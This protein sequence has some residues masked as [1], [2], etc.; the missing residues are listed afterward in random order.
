MQTNN[1]SGSGF[2]YSYDEKSKTIKIITNEHVVENS[3]WVQV[4]NDLG[5]S[6]DATIDGEDATRD[7]A[8]LSAC[9]VTFS[10]QIEVLSLLDSSQIKAGTSIFVIG[11]PR[12]VD[13]TV[14]TSGIVSAR[15]FQD[16]NDRWIIQTDAAMNPGNSG[17]PLL[18]MDGTVVGINTYGI[19]ESGG[20]RIEGQGF[21][22]ASE[23]VEEHIHKLQ[24]ATSGTSDPNP[25]PTTTPLVSCTT[26]VDCYDIG[27]RY[28]GDGDYLAALPY[29]T[30]GIRL[31]D[32]YSY[33]YLGR[34]VTF[35]KLRKYTEG[36]VDLKNATDPNFEHADSSFYWI[37]YA[38]LEMS[39][40][41][42]AVDAFSEA[43]QYKSTIPVFHYKR[44]T[45]YLELNQYQ[46]A[47]DDF[48][49]AIL[50]DPGNETY[51]G[52]RQKALTAKQNISPKVT[53]TFPSLYGAGTY[54][55]K[56]LDQANVMIQRKTNDNFQIEYKDSYKLVGLTD[57]QI[58]TGIGDNVYSVGSIRTSNIVKV[59]QHPA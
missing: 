25:T 49:K 20:I 19:I 57:S 48:D 9:C 42:Q 34:G 39:S 26:T 23:T 13:S 46:K 36:I 28:Y 37:G 12:G 31:D 8:V 51:I 40:W 22:V 47:I 45:A 21:A 2:V 56:N 15:F 59:R 3:S 16:S 1:G 4:K 11:Y 24:K 30:E 38:Y 58:L 5:L 10:S 29:F 52:A 6:L 41:Q 50:L 44:A 17:G 53:W 14:V 32:S 33:N 54:Y 55:Q 43:I 35:V 18:S 27:T 7:I